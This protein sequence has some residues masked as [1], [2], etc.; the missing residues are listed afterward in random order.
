MI[1]CLN[2]YLQNNICLINCFNYN[3]EFYIRIINQIIDISNYICLNSIQK[4]L[5]LM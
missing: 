1:D 4:E 2:Y 5:Y 3:F